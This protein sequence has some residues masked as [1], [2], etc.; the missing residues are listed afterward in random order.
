MANMVMNPGIPYVGPVPGGLQDGMRIII[1]GTPE[2]HHN[3]F[4]IFL[5]AGPGIDPRSDCAFVFNPRFN[6]NCVVRN[7][8]QMGS[9]G[10]EERSGGMPCHRGHPTTVE[11]HVQ[12]HHYKVSVNGRH[13]TEYNHRMPKHRVTHITV[14]Q[15]IRVESIRF[16]GPG[17]YPS[18]QVPPP[19]APYPAPG[20]A[21]PI[22]NPPVPFVQPIPG[23]VYPGKMIFVSGI[24]HPGA[25]RFNINLKCGGDTAFHFDARFNFGSDRNVIVRNAQQNGS[26]GPEEKQSP[27]FPFNYNQFFDMI[28]LVEHACIKVAVNNQHLLEFYHRIQPISRIDTLR[29]DGDVRLTQVRFQ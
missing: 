24:P 15:G 9:W 3:G 19:A 22:Y 11:I 12:P 7:T 17:M 23:G 14:E 8:Y 28:I 6:E 29:I 4:A 26:W 1:K 18:G 13:F 2:H 27:Y 25:S 10:S 21:A 5:Q 16:E 20:G